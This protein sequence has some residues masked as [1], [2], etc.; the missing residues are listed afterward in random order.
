MK[1][2]VPLKRV[3][4]PDTKIRL[5]PDGSGVEVDGVKFAVN[6]FDAIALE[7]ALRAYT[8]NAAFAG[9]EEK[10]KGTLAPGKLADFVVLSRDP[11]TIPVR[12]LDGVRVDRTVVG[13][14]TIYSRA[15]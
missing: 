7:E 10:E 8:A 6:P 12:E 2:L 3:P 1:I 5:K 15:D 13:G 4:D 11:L 9:F 14:R